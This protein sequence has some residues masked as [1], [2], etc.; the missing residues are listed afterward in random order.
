MKKLVVDGRRTGDFIR[1]QLGM[2]GDCRGN[3]LPCSWSQWSGHLH[4]RLVLPS[5]FWTW[6]LWKFQSRFMVSPTQPLPYLL[7]ILAT[8]I[9]LHSFN[10]PNTWIFPPFFVAC[11]VLPRPLRPFP[12]CT[13][14]LRPLRTASPVWSPSRRPSTRSTWDPRRRCT[15]SCAPGPRCCSTVL[16]AWTLGM[17]NSLE[18]ICSM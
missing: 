11:P 13:W 16:W 3:C 9:S 4:P 6:Q 14:A 18:E 7:L 17:E 15:P 5:P 8:Q 1:S 12:P 10:L 2:L